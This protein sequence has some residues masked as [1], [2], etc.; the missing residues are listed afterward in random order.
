[1]EGFVIFISVAALGLMLYQVFKIGMFYGE[2]KAL[3][4]IYG[5]TPEE[6]INNIL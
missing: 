6:S 4:E 1:M 5:G 3:D 2:E